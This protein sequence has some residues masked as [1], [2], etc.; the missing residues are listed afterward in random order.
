LPLIASMLGVGRET[1]TETA[2]NLQRTD[3]I[4]YR[5][6]HIMVLDRSELESRICEC[7]AVVKNEFDRL[8]CD[9]RNRQEL[10]LAGHG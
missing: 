7:Y 4:S 1:I 2:R 3:L 5:R 9:V 8:L 10:P 6:G